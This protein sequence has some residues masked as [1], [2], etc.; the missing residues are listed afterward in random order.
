MAAAHAVAASVAAA[1]LQI[2][3]HRGL[4]AP[5][6]GGARPC[7]TSRAAILKVRSL[8]AVRWY[9]RYGVSYRDLEQMMGERGVSVDHSTIYRWVQKYAPEIE[10]RPRWQGLSEQY[11]FMCN[12]GNAPTRERPFRP[13]ERATPPTRPS[14]FACRVRD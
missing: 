3:R 6:V 5:N 12:W 13:Q 2:R 11:E 8:C 10:K 4:M 7:R 1:L 9:C 14:V